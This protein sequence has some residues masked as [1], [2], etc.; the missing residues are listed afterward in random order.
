MSKQESNF[1]GVSGSY[2]MV[3]SRHLVVILGWGEVARRLFRSFLGKR[4]FQKRDK[5]K[6]ET[7]RQYT[8]SRIV[9]CLD[10]CVKDTNETTERNPPCLTKETNELLECLRAKAGAKNKKK[11]DASS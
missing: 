1:V 6:I 2:G 8:V 4:P 7:K 10:E 9:G 5:T 11:S 3:A